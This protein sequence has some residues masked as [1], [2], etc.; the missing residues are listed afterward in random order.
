MKFGR[1]TALYPTEKRSGSN[2]I[3]HCKCDCGSECDI[4]SNSLMRGRATSCGCLKSKG[5]E[6]VSRLLRERNIN[7]K[8]QYTDN[9]FTRQSTG[10]KFRFDFCLLDNENQ[11]LAFIEYNGIQH[12]QYS[13]TGWNT[14]EQFEKTFE[15]D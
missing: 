6:T 1:L 5:E 2:V 7:F 11:L 3:W 8:A 12:Y 9:R 14:K 4:S 10:S 15:R 13:G